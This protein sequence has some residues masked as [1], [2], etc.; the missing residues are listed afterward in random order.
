MLESMKLHLAEFVLGAYENPRRALFASREDET[1]F[2]FVYQH[3]KTDAFCHEHALH[4]FSFYFTFDFASYL[5]LVLF[6]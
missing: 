6:V 3:K 1:G 2:F 4:F 5:I